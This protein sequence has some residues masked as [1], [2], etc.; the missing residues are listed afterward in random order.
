MTLYRRAV[1]GGALALPAVSRRAGGSRA[2][3]VGALYPF[4]GMLSLFGDESYR[5][6]ELAADERN[7]RGRRCS[8]GR[9]S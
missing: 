4:S 1:L 3:A 7:A 9:S 6:L 8:T 2:A 5:G